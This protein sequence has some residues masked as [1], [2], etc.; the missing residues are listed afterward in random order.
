VA[1]SPV[2][3]SIAERPYPGE[4]V[5][6]DGWQVDRYGDVCRIAVNDG[7]GHGEPAAEATRTAK[8]VLAHHPEMPPVE[9]LRACHR[10]IFS[11]RGAAMWVA[12]VEVHRAR[13]S[14]AGVGNVDARLLQGG[15]EHRLVP[16]RG[17]VGATLPNLRAVERELLP[18]WLLLVYTDGIRDRFELEAMPERLVRDPQ[19]LADDILHTWGRATDDA[20]V[21]VAQAHADF[22][23][24][25]QMTPPC[26]DN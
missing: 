19:A 10:G 22:A 6:G 15:R 2:V 26:A 17:I 3:V 12:A 23:L 5:S 16:Q 14:Y 7:L 24:G 8:D 20:L 18:R 4:R 13:L 11:T 25:T 21:L 9:A 1:S